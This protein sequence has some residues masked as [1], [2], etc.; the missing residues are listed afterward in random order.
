MIVS[1]AKGDSYTPD[2]WLPL[3]GRDL[4]KAQRQPVHPVMIKDGKAGLF[5]H[6][7][8]G[9][10]PVGTKIGLRMHGSRL[11]VVETGGG[12]PVQEPRFWDGRDPILELD[13][14]EGAAT[15]LGIEDPFLGTLF[16]GEDGLEILPIR[17]EEHGPDVLGPRVID[18]LRTPL[19]EA[20]PAEIVRHVV[21]GPTYEEWTRDR[22]RGL[23]DLLCS[24]PF[25]H[26]PLTPLADGEDW[27]AWKVRGEILRRPRDDDSRQRGEF[28][29]AAFSDQ[30]ENG[31]WFDSPLKTAYGMLHALSVG[32]GPKE[33]RM[34][35]AA[36][37][38]LGW[39]AP[40][41]RPGMWMLSDSHRREWNASRSRQGGGK[42]RSFPIGSPD[43][44]VRFVREEAQQR[45]MATCARHFSGL[46]DAMLHVSATAA[47][48]LCR[49]G[50]AHHPR[51]KS[52]ANSMLQLA[53]MFG[54][55]CACWGIHDFSRAVD[56][57][58]A[59]EP[60]F[61]LRAD[62]RDIAL[63]SIP[64]GYGRDRE[65]LRFLAR[66]PQCPGMHR[67]DL[68][69]TNGWWPY[70]WRDIGLRD[71]FAVVGSYWQNAD[72]WAKANRALTQFP[73]CRGSTTEFFALFQ[74]HLYQ[75]SQGEWNQGYPAGMLE[76]ISEVTR[77]ARRERDIDE[78]PVLRF[79]KLMVL[80]TVPWL[81]EHQGEDGTWD[82]AEL[83]RRGEGADLPALS[84]RLATY[85]I[86][87]ALNEFGLL[88]RLRPAIPTV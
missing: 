68:A 25:Q 16:D 75:T 72:C 76:W 26:D 82:H 77:N 3:M 70:E 11:L 60:D 87:T 85:H 66:F 41:G 20:Q 13:L 65:D 84:A 49:C 33:P 57:L 22:V 19:D 81:R 55:F 23:E 63:R 10:L 21:R 29:R 24:T 18:E 14:P 78:S 47:F 6:G 36:E 48:A 30:S 8:M 74:C 32:V 62:Q 9:R 56:P 35:K 15:A 58:Q 79:A 80:K 12:T 44:D 2:R 39:P 64:Y 34:R 71:H 43:E 50:Y 54:Y 83:S 38:L 31:S 59:N 88:D 52:Y 45:A 40:A 69:D 46:C 53:A 27:V 37:W 1:A 61:E 51:L 5:S 42:P 28:V 17:V 73:G 67:P 86:V 4:A 7:V